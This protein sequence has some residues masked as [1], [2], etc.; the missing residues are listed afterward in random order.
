MVLILYHQYHSSQIIFFNLKFGIGQVAERNGSCD[1]GDPL[2]LAVLADC[3]YHC[4]SNKHSN[5]ICGCCMAI[6]SDC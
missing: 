5:G 1:D 2:N 3:I 4:I 6:S